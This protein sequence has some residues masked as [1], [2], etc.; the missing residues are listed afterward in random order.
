MINNN[1]KIYFKGLYGLR[2]IAASAVV[3]SHIEQVKLNHKYFSIFNFPLINNFGFCG[4]ILFFVLSGFLITYLLLAEKQ[5][6]NSISIKNFYIRRILRI[7]PLYFLVIALNFFIIPYISSF[8]QSGAFSEMI[9]Q[10]HFFEKTALSLVF[11]PHIAI[12]LFPSIPCGQIWTIGLEEQFY[13][14]W[15]LIIKFFKKYLLFTIL[16]INL[17]FICASYY[18]TNV[19]HV[20][21]LNSYFSMLKLDCMVIGAIGAY[22]LYFEKY[23]ILKI[24]YNKFFQIL[25]SITLIYIIYFQKSFGYI[26]NEIYSIL[27]T[28]LIINICSNPKSIIKLENKVFKFLGKISYGIYMYQFFA[29]EIALN[30]SKLIFHN[31][32]NE[33]FSNI[34]LYL[35]TFAILILISSISYLYFENLF[36][37][38][39]GKFTIIQSE[40]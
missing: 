26:N 14:I 25:S 8:W 2:F 11:L 7:W 39:K 18:V 35:S 22:I 23:L 27:F 19:K 20:F 4:V 1:E 37:K 33:I 12:I 17:F 36:L 10:K 28:I 29:I 3:I 16:I 32:F 13:L 5:T 30:L 6:R 38:L 9:N 21:L 15:P 24:L 40:D 31:Q 34:V